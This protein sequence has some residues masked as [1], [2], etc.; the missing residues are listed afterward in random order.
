MFK[1]MIVALYFLLFFLICLWIMQLI[2]GET[3]YIDK[4]THALVSTL[5][6]TKMNVF[7]SL[8]T[9]LGGRTFLI[10]FTIVMSVILGILYRN[11][12]PAI[13]LGLGT[14]GGHLVNIVIKELVERERPSIS[15]ALHAE[16]YSFPSGHAM[17]AIVCFGI[18]TYFLTK[19]INS[20]RGKILVW[21]MT[22]I[23]IFIVGMSRYVINVHFL[24]DVIAGYFFGSLYVFILLY[25]Y[26]KVAHWKKGFNNIEF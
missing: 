17:N 20:E 10:P 6:G 23:L 26:Q 24:T 9:I 16:G 2:Q 14:Y 18:L 8:A 5:A 12:L 19:K 22:S 21:T 11:V 25:L 7:F 15:V 4:Y 3:P 13:F 1:K